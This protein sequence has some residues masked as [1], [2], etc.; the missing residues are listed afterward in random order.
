MQTLLQCEQS[1]REVMHDS[2]RCSVA[3]IDLGVTHNSQQHFIFLCMFCA[4]LCEP[5]V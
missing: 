2:E 4:R 3:C 1:H 5:K